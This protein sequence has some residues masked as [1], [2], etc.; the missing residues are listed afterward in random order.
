MERY[1]LAVNANSACTDKCD[2]QAL[3][4]DPAECWCYTILRWVYLQGAACWE[5]NATSCEIKILLNWHQMSVNTYI[6]PA[7]YHFG[8]ICVPRLDIVLDH[9]DQ[10]KRSHPLQP[11][12]LN[13]HAQ[14]VYIFIDSVHVWSLEGATHCLWIQR[15]HVC[16]HL[17]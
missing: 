5:I 6:N 8:A 12:W 15:Q 7:Y 9:Y 14:I 17:K 13:T 16:K 11:H 10:D 3:C 2:D 1:L 4:V